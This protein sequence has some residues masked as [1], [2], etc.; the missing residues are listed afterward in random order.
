QHDE[1]TAVRTF[2]LGLVER[3]AE[4]YLEK[5][6]QD[7]ESWLRKHPL[8][9]DVW[10][11][12]I[13]ILTRTHQPSHA[14]EIASAAI[15]F[16][17]RDQNLLEHY[18]DLIASQATEEEVE[19][20][21][22]ELRTLAPKNKVIP[23]RR[24]KWLSERGRNE[25]AE[26]AFSRLLDEYP[27]WF[28]IRHAYGRHLLG[29]EKWSEAVKLFEAALDL[30]KGFQVAHEGKALALRGLGARAIEAGDSKNADMYLR[31]AERHFKS[32]I[33]WARTNSAPTARFYTS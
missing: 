30:H 33:H 12:L 15:S 9:T 26:I 29:L 6:V 1:D 2:Y 32:A 25:E 21:F 31:Q 14:A 23:L 4:N 20:V 3:K 13:A 24:A 27:G 7:T 19:R 18:L 22:A 28:Q 10:S 11:I 16:H 8:A 17:P 5:A